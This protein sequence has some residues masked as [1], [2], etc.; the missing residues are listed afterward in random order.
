MGRWRNPG[1]D[2]C[3]GL[4]CCS[5]ARANQ[6]IRLAEPVPAKGPDVRRD[7]D[8]GGGVPLLD[9]ARLHYLTGIH[10]IMTRSV[11]GLASGPAG[12]NRPL[13]L[14][15][16]RFDDKNPAWSPDGSRIAF[17]RKLN[18]E[19]LQ[20]V[21]IPAGGGPEQ[22]IANV[23]GHH[24]QPSARKYM[25]GAPGGEALVAAQRLEGAFG[26]R[27]RKFPLSGGASQPVTEGPDNTIDVSPAFSRDG[28]WLAYLR[29]EN[30]ATYGLWAVAQ[31]GTKPKRLVTSRVPITTFT[32]KP[33]S[34][35]I[36][37]GGG[38]LS[39]GELWQVSVAGDRAIAPFVLE[40]TADEIT[41]APN[42]VR[43]AYVLQNLD[44]NI[45]RVPLAGTRQKNL[46]PPEKL[47]ASI[48]EE[49]DPAVSSDGKSI[50]FISNRSGRWNL[51]VGNADGS[52]LREL[53]AQSLLPFHPAWSPD[54]RTIAFDSKASG[55]AQIWLIHTGGGP[56]ARLVTMPG[57]AEV[58][59]WSSDG[60]RILLT[61]TAHGKSGRSRRQVGHRFS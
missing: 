49:T 19:V 4:A 58:P 23:P 24:F 61:P 3:H 39:T 22:M 38:A 60:R 20:A 6:F 8:V 40:G 56:P 44:S 30:G 42:G 46:P 16:G 7:N 53:E 47:F 29:W 48:R 32:W 52:G 13:I 1:L 10:H 34:R 55:S 50:A 15:S 35:T 31:P 2:G 59:S 28:R 12:S 21:V 33:D 11:A 41:I 18:A 45:W 9:S 27:L 54:S 26:L 17:L 57:G 36:V 51:W 37:Y 25:T 14:T 5:F 43:L